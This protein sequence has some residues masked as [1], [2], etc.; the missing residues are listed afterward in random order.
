MSQSELTS[1]RISPHATTPAVSVIIPAYN[2][3]RLIGETL[4]SV[5]AQTLTDY[6]VIIVNDGSPD[7]KELEKVLQPFSARLNY[8]EQKNSGPAGARNTAINAARGEF[9]AFL[10]SDDIW[11]PSYLAEQLE[12]LRADSSIAVVSA[13]ATLFGDSTLAGQTFLQLWPSHEPVTVS[14]LLTM[15]CAVLTSCVV[16]RKAR[17]IGAGL[18]DTRFMR[19]EDYDLW[20]RLAHKGERF[21][22]NHKVLARHRVHGAS[23]AADEKSLFESQ[24]AVYQKLS[25]A[26]EVSDELRQ[27]IARQIERCEA[28]I[29]LLQGKSQLMAGQYAQAIAALNRAHNFYRTHKLRLALFSLRIAPGLLRRAYQ[30]Q[31]RRSTR[32][33]NAV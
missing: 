10:D 26:D 6:E 9:V 19:S 1:S 24:I 21:A 33:V 22:Y 17:L 4:S 12:V 25:Q 20:L 7:T 18:F 14:K 27:L 13:D 3:A 23:L 31:Q 11:L 28:D 32:S 15:R 30:F 29:A 5:F 2:C 8:I 16:A